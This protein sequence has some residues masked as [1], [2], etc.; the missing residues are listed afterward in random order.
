MLP[1]LSF[2]SFTNSIFSIEG[3]LFYSI[4]IAKSFPFVLEIFNQL[5]ML[6]NQP[7]HVEFSYRTGKDEVFPFT[8]G[9]RSI[10]LK[11]QKEM[12]Y[13]WLVSKHD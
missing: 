8:L 1:I 11:V 12:L 5:A 4:L 9:T 10:L 7:S 2:Y 13:F 3:H 6:T